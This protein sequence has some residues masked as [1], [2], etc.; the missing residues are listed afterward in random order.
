MLSFT[1]GGD[2]LNFELG[3]LL[4]CPT[5][6]LW[7]LSRRSFLHRLLMLLTRSRRKT[8]ST[9]QLEVRGDICA[10]ASASVEGGA[11]DRRFT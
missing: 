11:S 6:A 9:R 4:R 3:N 1:N 8:T 5:S 2:P 10:S 7:A